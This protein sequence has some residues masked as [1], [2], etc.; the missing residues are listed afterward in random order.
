V[1][2]DRIRWLDE[3]GANFNAAY[4]RVMAEQPTA[5]VLISLDH[6][7]GDALER[8]AAADATLAGTTVLRGLAAR[9]GDRQWRVAMHPYP[10][11]LRSDVFGPDDFPYVTYGTIG[12]LA[13]WLRA[14]F[15]ARPSAWEIQL[16][17][18]GIN[19]LTPSTPDR[20]ATAV[21]DTFRNVLGTPGIVNY[22]YHRM[23]DHPAETAAGLGLGL[24]N[25]D[26]TAK[27]AWATWAP[28]N[29]NDLS[30]P[31]LSCGF[32]RL[33]YTR[34]VRGYHPSRGHWALMAAIVLAGPY[35]V[36]MPGVGQ[37]QEC[38]RVSDGR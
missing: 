8:P 19:S 1:A 27:P 14:T 32:E 18:S 30:P 5:K 17:E 31:R 16:T 11:D 2:C 34:L 15:P 9:V 28:A 23:R 4:D 29:R 35:T 22:V 24:R 36:M 21:C 13:G 10:R 3:I 33:P 26:G 25:A 6:Q 12:A 37:G 7:F 38:A 20:Q